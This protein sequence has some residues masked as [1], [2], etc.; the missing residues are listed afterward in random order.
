MLSH[1]FF[2]LILACLCPG[3]GHCGSHLCLHESHRSAWGSGALA[4][5]PLQKSSASSLGHHL[6]DK[7]EALGGT[8][9]TFIGVLHI[10][11][12]AIGSGLR[13]LCWMCVTTT[14][15]SKR[16]TNITVLY[17]SSALLSFILEMTTACAVC[18]WL[19][20][21]MSKKSTWLTCALWDLM[22]SMEWPVSTLKSSKTQCRKFYFLPL[23][24][25]R[26]ENVWP[27]M[28]T[29]KFCVYLRFSNLSIPRFKDFYE[30]DPQKFQNK[31]NG[32]TPRRWLVM[33]NPGLA[34]VIAEVCLFVLAEM[35]FQTLPTY[36]TDGYI[37]LLGFEHETAPNI[38]CTYGWTKLN[39]PSP[40]DQN[41]Q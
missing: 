23:L 17:P 40:S 15:Q 24:Y 5:R 31:T 25:S 10:C 8:W 9:Q 37:M 4:C 3:L 13:I 32:I 38:D 19:R 39:Q 7:Q 41:K 34:D 6:W 30:I 27:E 33:C 20:K 11:I 28:W 36:L 16:A 35:S 22:L 12:H 21:G 1:S 29:I 2:F 18:P 14:W 26:E